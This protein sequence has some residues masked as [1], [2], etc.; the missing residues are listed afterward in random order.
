MKNLKEYD[1]FGSVEESSEHLS[2][3]SCM[4]QAAMEALKSACQSCLMKEAQDYDGDEDPEHTFEGYVTKCM[5]Y[6]KECM[7][8]TGYSSLANPYKG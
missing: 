3:G 8:Q 5:E 7:G 1:F 6:L 2:E 4:S